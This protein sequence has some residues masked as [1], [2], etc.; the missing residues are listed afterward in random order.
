MT[1]LGKQINNRALLYTMMLRVPHNTDS[2]LY[3]CSI[4]YTYICGRVYILSIIHT[5][6]M[7]Y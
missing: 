3:T 5:K 2:G 6:K 1:L 4:I 7:L